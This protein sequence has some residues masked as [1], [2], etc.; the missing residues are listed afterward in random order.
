M[1]EIDILE[2]YKEALLEYSKREEQPIPSEHFRPSSLAGGCGRMLYYQRIGAEL[3]KED[4][5]DDWTY[6]LKGITNTGTHRHEVIQEIVKH[7]K[8][9][10]YLTE[11][12]IRELIKDTDTE[13]VHKDGEEYRFKNDKLKLYFQ[14]DGILEID[15]E[16]VLLEIKTTSIFNWGKLKEPMKNHIEQAN[17]YAMGLGI[18]KILFMYEDRNFTRM[19]TYIVDTDEQL[20]ATIKYKIANIENYLK[21]NRTPPKETNK[22]R[23]CRYKTVCSKEGKNV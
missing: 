17:I 16:I 6:N 12:E 23:Y 4:I 15:G 5:K 3:D 7:M 13:L 21:Q 20:Q 14:P 1:A 9:V 18:D 19:K 8:G 2:R 22:C 10:R 11:G